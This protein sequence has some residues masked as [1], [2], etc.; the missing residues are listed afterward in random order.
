M[1]PP[2]DR[3]LEEE[4]AWAHNLGWKARADRDALAAKL[5][6]SGAS[7]RAVASRLGTS[8]HFA[9]RAVLR[10]GAGGGVSI[11]ARGRARS[12][13]TPALVEREDAIRR[14]YACG[15]TLREIAREHGVST[16]RVRQILARLGLRRREERR[17]RGADILEKALREAP[18]HRN[19]SA[20]ARAIGV[21]LDVLR[22]TRG[23][24]EVRARL[25]ENGRKL[26]ERN[27][28]AIKRFHEEKRLSNAEIG[29]LLHVSRR[30]VRDCLRQIGV[31]PNSRAMGLVDGR[32]VALTREELDRRNREI[33]RLVL[34]GVPV[35]EIAEGVGLCVGSVRLIFRTR[36]K[37]ERPEGESR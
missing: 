23:V 2:R 5:Y 9:R 27:T 24:A 22:F 31:A 35:R 18:R 37:A 30:Y 14:A 36:K 4:E 29:R 32:V 7:L 25:A 11:R 15:E 34:A 12:P 13:A 26:C 6:A 33:H 17:A 28:S 8:I 10:G 16:E 3:P 20:L 1:T 19:L 21:P